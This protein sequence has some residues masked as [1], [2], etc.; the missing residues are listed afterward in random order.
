MLFIPSKASKTLEVSQSLE[1]NLNITFVVKYF[2]NNINTAKK[3]A[4]PSSMPLF[5]IA[6]QSNNCL[7]SGFN[8]CNKDQFKTKMKSNGSIISAEI[9]RMKNSFC[10][11]KTE[12]LP[13]NS[14]KNGLII[15]VRMGLNVNFFDYVHSNDL[16]HINQHIQN[17][18]YFL[19]FF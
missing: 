13:N 9:D 19:N 4:L 16:N 1:P 14:T 11:M 12:T 2:K 10:D 17:G 6:Q 7:S 18:I 15:D 8:E 5:D 3:T